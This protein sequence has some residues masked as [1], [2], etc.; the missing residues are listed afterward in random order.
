MVKSGY[1]IAFLDYKERFVA[2]WN[3]PSPSGLIG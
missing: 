2:H 3:T 1:E